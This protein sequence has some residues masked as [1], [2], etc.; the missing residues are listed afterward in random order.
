M[1]T[2]PLVRVASARP[3]RWG[4][5]LLT[6]ALAPVTLALTTVAPAD[7]AVVTCHGVR[8]TIVAKPGAT[9]VRGTPGRD[10]IVGTAGN[11]TILAGGGNDLVCG[12]AGADTINGGPGNDRLY[13]QLDDWEPGV[14]EDRPTIAGDT[15]IGGPGNDL[16][17]AGYDSRKGPDGYIPDTISWEG[18]SHGVHLDYRTRTARG[19]G[20]DT[21][22]RGLFLA[23]GTRFADVVEGSNRAEWVETLGGRD[24]VRGRGGRDTIGVDGHA[25]SRAG[26]ADRVWGGGGRDHITARHGRDQIWGGAGDDWIE[27]SGS[28]ND[29]LYGGDGHDVIQAW[30]GTK[31]GPQVVDGGPGRDIVGITTDATN[32]DRVASTG[33]WNMATG[34][35]TVTVDA[36][37]R[38]GSAAQTYRLSV[39]HVEQGGFATTT[40]KVP[41]AAWTITGTQGDDGIYGDG[42]QTVPMHFSGRGG[43]DTFSGTDGDDWFDG[44]PG[45]DSGIMSRGDDTCI[46]VETIRYA[47]CEHVS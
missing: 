13:G 21:F 16:L 9:V 17:D 15:L 1:S 29:M 14:D 31:R 37:S 30:I 6:F 19:Q 20:H 47:D 2:S 36:S 18:A 22:A 38:A 12:G 39:R 45:D 46:S 42:N 43:D 26:D 41:D 10:V 25:R 35:M 8:A 44:G 23:V 40:W 4:A 7:A 27:S 5:V 32:P 34:V 24:I 28:S 3:T 33:N 11:D